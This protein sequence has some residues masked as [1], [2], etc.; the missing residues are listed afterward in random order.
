MKTRVEN[1][2]VT[3]LMESDIIPSSN[4]DTFVDFD[5]DFNIPQMLNLETSELRISPRIVAQKRTD[6]TCAI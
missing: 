5:Q 6:G 1:S 2:S 4:I 3:P